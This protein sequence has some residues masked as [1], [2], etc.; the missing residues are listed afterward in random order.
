MT[1]RTRN[2]YCRISRQNAYYPFHVV[3]EDVQRHFGA[4]VLERFHLEVRRSHPRLYGAEGC[5]IGA[6][7]RLHAYVIGFAVPLAR[8]NGYPGIAAQVRSDASYFLRQH[9]TGPEG[10]KL[11]LK[12]Q[13]CGIIGVMCALKVEEKSAHVQNTR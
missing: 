11:A 10:V 4:D 6:E 2:L 7:W 1:I 8:H 3:G 12:W 9:L 5:S 13:A